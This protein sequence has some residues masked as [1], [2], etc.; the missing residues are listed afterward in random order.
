MLNA[1]ADVPTEVRQLWTKPLTYIRIVHGRYCISLVT[2]CFVPRRVPLPDT[3]S[4]PM[5]GPHLPMNEHKRTSM[6]RSQA[7]DRNW[8]H[9]S[10]IS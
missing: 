8:N 10:L 4:R 5:W 9:N 2:E 6:N 3:A 7:R 1:H